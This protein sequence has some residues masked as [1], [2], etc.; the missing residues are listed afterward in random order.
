M[1]RSEAEDLLDKNFR[2]LCDESEGLKE[3]EIQKKKLVKNY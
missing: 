1:N 2:L 3:L